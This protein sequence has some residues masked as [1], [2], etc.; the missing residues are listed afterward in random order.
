MCYFEFIL[1]IS[2]L[3]FSIF[4]F[5]L[6]CF[7]RSLCLG[8][9][10]SASP[11]LKKGNVVNM[12]RAPQ[13]NLTQSKLT[14]ML[15]SQAPKKPL[16][17]QPVMDI[18][19]VPTPMPE[20]MDT[21]QAPGQSTSAGSVPAGAHPPA[22]TATN[23]PPPPGGPPSQASGS[24]SQV[25]STEFLLKSLRENTDYILKSFSSHMS[26]LAN[27]VDKNAGRISSNSTAIGDN[28]TAIDAQGSEIRHLSERV[29]AL[30][31][32]PRRQEVDG[33]A[34]AQL[35]REYLDA[36]RLV[37]LWPVVGDIDSELWERVGEFIL[38]IL[39]VDTKEV[40]QDDIELVSRII[41]SSLRNA[42]DR[43]EVLVTFFDKA[44]RDTVFSHSINLSGLVDGSGNPTAG[45]CLEIHKDLE[46]T[47]RFLSRFGTRL[48]ARLG[49]GTKRHIKF[50]DF[51]GSLYTNIKLP[52]DETWTRVS[53]KTAQEDLQA[54]ERRICSRKRDWP[55][56]W[57]PAPENV[58]AATSLSWMHE[59]T[60]LLYHRNL[61]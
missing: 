16:V 17:E 31:S 43:Q 36:R 50:D 53:P 23:N 37:R 55:R 52:G 4:L 15:Q 54:S 28:R 48:R 59:L 29:R 45:L 26:A 42:P 13:P 57:S 2:R 9:Q 1:K 5:L 41:D 60:L 11:D 19:G 24:H 58:S 21:G 27:R 22:S 39:R 61:V 14:S 6:F 38:D 30:E 34:R 7:Y 44:V 12:R 35:S 32:A 40:C 20:R 3:N 25:V 56:S 46:S 33:V 47:I 49:A 18:S 8:R 10:Q 51:N